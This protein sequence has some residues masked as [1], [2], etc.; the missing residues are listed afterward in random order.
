MVNHIVS[1]VGWG[2]ET[3][4]NPDTDAQEEVHYWIVRNSWGTYWGE[5]GYFRIEMGKNSLGIEMTVAWATPKTFTVD[6]VPCA[7]DGENCHHDST[8]GTQTYVDPSLRQDAFLRQRGIQ[9]VT[10]NN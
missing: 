9:R 10:A 7:E 8:V 6:N 1:I 2:T 3:V 4:V 5:M